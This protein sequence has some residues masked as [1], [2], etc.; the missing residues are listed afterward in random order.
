M[1]M[2]TNINIPQSIIEWMSYY[3]FIKFS[4]I[5]SLKWHILCHFLSLSQPCRSLLYK[6]ISAGTT[7]NKA[8]LSGLCILHLTQVDVLHFF[9]CFLPECTGNLKQIDA[10]A[11]KCRNGKAGLQGPKA[12][13]SWVSVQC[14]QLLSLHYCAVV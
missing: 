7:W 12:E 8:V 10:C 4:L 13:C 5:H 6:P 1:L 11:G 3:F 9:H 14:F 2:F